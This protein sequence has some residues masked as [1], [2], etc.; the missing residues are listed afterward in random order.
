M[1]LGWAWDAA[2][3]Y[4]SL[5]GCGEQLDLW[6]EGGGTKPL[7]LPTHLAFTAD[8][9]CGGTAGA[10]VGRRGVGAG[11]VRL[12]HHQL[13]QVPQVVRLDLALPLRHLRTSQPSS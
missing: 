5:G 7:P 8:E 9:A 6:D 4:C 12:G 1:L 13:L 3:R 11:A 10:L 2:G